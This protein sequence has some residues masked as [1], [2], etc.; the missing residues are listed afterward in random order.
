MPRLPKDTPPDI[1]GLFWLLAQECRRDYMAAYMRRRRA[2]QRRRG[3]YE[4]PPYDPQHAAYM[5]DW[6]AQQPKPAPKPRKPPVSSTKGY[7]A[8]GMRAWRAKHRKP[9]K[10]TPEYRSEWTRHWHQQR[11]LANDP[12]AVRC[13]DCQHLSANGRGCTLLRVP[14]VEM[15][16]RLCGDFS[17]P[18][19]TW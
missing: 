14:V 8:A 6:R 10:W 19:Q 3:T 16:L 15:D 11:R 2:R 7:K 5:R 18:W 4:P 1:A 9:T 17:A 13:R 12:N